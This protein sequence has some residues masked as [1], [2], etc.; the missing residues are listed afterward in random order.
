MR[1]VVVPSPL[2]PLVRAA[3]TSTKTRAITL[4]QVEPSPWGPT[5]LSVLVLARLALVP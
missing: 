1:L 3:A 5:A 2:V 4:V